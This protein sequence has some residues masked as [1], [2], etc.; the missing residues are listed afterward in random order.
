MNNRIIKKQAMLDR[1]EIMTLIMMRNRE[2]NIFNILPREL[3]SYIY[4]TSHDSYDKDSDIAILLHHIAYGEKKAAEK[5]LKKNPGLLLDVS[6]VCDPAGNYIL[7]IRPYECALAAGDGD[8]KRMIS[9]YFSNIPEG[10]QEMEKQYAKYSKHIDN[11]LSRKP[12]YDLEEL[13]RFILKSSDKDV[14]AALDCDMEYK[15][16]LSNALSVFRKHFSPRV[17]T[18]GMHFNYQ[19]LVQAYYLY[20]REYENLQQNRCSYDKC[21]LFWRQVIGYIQRGLPACDRQAL[22]QGLSFCVIKHK[23]QR[24][25]TFRSGGGQF[26]VTAND[27]SPEGLGYKNAVTIMGE[28]GA[29]T[30]FLYALLGLG[31][32]KS[33]LKRKQRVCRSSFGKAKVINRLGM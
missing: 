24:K 21:N 1:S 29:G 3:T 12:D 2:D 15:S 33:Y 10:E 30:V 8:M 26:P 27:H 11:M 17:I 13:M 18:E 20:Q 22:A 19:N 25:F 5:M 7:A 14:K 31:Q 9:G 28:Q 23:L 4:K 16:E 6:N 32:L